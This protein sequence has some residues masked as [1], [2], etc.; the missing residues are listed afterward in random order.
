M[1]TVL[2]MG[3][4]TISKVLFIIGGLGVTVVFGRSEDNLE[5]L[6]PLFYPV[7]PGD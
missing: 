5:E 2:G 1:K 7:G 6:M 3:L 4:L